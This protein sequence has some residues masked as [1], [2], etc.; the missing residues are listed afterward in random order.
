MCIRDRVAL[1]VRPCLP[2]EIAR[3]AKECLTYP[4]KGEPQVSLQ[5][6]QAFTY[7]YV[8]PP[9]SNQEEMFNTCV[10]PLVEGCFNGYNATILAYGQTGS[11]KTYTMGSGGSVIENDPGIIPR[12]MEE[13]IKMKNQSD[14]TS[15]CLLYT[16][17][18]AD[19][20]DSGI[21]GGVRGS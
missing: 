10:A 16:S 8:F 20:E 1:R 9:S 3:G 4:V 15:T 2:Q 19:E 12:V 18:A 14:S 11:G 21:L 17:D 5:G 6:S 7:D 13:I